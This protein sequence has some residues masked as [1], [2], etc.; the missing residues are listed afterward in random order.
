MKLLR[1]VP[2]LGLT[3][4]KEIKPINETFSHDIIRQSAATPRR[5]PKR[6]QTD[7]NV[8]VNI[9]NINVY[10]S[11]LFH[12]PKQISFPF[13][14]FLPLLNTISI[15]KTGK[16]CANF[17]TFFPSFFALLLRGFLLLISV[18]HPTHIH[19]PKAFSALR[20]IFMLTART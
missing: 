4:S 6:F 14:S 15:F 2:T 9:K 18:E 17:S 3:R 12:Y 10:P 7:L 11:L 20:N 8:C 16:H 5:I 1:H 19:S 13:F